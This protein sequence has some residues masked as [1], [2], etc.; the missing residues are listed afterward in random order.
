MTQ[1]SLVPEKI[2]PGCLIGQPQG[3]VRLNHIPFEDTVPEL[4]EKGVFDDRP[5]LVTRMDDFSAVS[6]AP[7]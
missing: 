4:P 2:R 3:P 1:H 5:R 7:R 6:Q